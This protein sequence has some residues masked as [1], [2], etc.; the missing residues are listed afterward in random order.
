[1]TFENYLSEM[2]MQNYRGIDDD[3]PEAFSNWLVNL[4]VD[5]L[6]AHAETW[7]NLMF[8]K[9]KSSITYEDIEDFQE[10]E[11][12]RKHRELN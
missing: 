3:A 7:G 5:T 1:M 6:I 8:K 2:H 10:K 9:G 11:A 12:E 4:P